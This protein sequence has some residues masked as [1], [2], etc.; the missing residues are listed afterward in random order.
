M[1]DTGQPLV[2]IIDELDRCRPT[3]A[4]E[5]L[6]RVKHIFDIPGIVFVFGINQKELCSSIK[7]VYG[8]IDAG[9][10]LRRFFDISLS[11]PDANAVDFC[12]YL[13]DK[14]YE[15]NKLFSALSETAKNS[16]H[17]EEFRDFSESI[18]PLY[19]RLNLSLRD[20]DSCIRSM[21]F[22][23]KN[24]RE[25]HYMFPYLI[26]TL[27]ALRLKNPPLYQGFLK[28][29][30]LGSEVVNYIDEQIPDVMPNTPL[31]GVLS[32]IEIDLYSTSKE[33]LR[34]LDVL[35]S[36]SKL[37]QPELLSERIKKDVEGAKKI[38][39]YIRNRY[40][41]VMNEPY[42]NLPYIR[43]LIELTQAK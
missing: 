31:Y 1:N 38:S 33:A 20:I 40:F 34:E 9:V 22:V 12:K 19:N 8:E 39:S 26:G 41:H 21:F 42:I 13:I 27:I 18:P 10:Y 6:E 23:A 4:I 36:G 7:S 24:I 43:S 32:A 35:Q 37:T 14:K 30:R 11:L 5:L 15:L 2:F 28:G 25:K 29:E 3:F 16:V 17:T